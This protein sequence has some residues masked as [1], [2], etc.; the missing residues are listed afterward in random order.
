M[1]S[2][3]SKCISFGGSK[4][5][6]GLHSRSED[7]EAFHAAF[8]DD[9]YMEWM[10]GFFGLK[11]LANAL[12]APFPPPPAPER[13]K[14]TFNI[15][16]FITDG[17]EDGGFDQPCCFGNRVSGHAVYCHNEAWPNSPRKCRRDREEYKHEDCPGFVLN[18]DWTL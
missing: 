4:E 15:V 12:T 10:K 5:A 9:A 13:F 6:I 7:V 18:P 8:K 14:R 11:N 17:E 16:E 1:V 3:A 2:A